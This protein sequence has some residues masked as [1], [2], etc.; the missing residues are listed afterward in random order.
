MKF[1]LYEST[2]RLIINFWKINYLIKLFRCLTQANTLSVNSIGY[3]EHNMVASCNRI[4]CDVR[5]ANGKF[6]NTKSNANCA[7]S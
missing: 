3:V 2:I 1:Y 4:D 7:F 6:S 5:S